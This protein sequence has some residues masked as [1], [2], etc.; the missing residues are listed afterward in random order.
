MR[1][2]QLEADGW[3]VVSYERVNPQWTRLTV[4]CVGQ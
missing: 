2:A 4:W 3:D 1:I